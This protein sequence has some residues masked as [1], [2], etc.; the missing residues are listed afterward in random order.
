MSQVDWS[1]APE[2]AQ[3]YVEGWGFFRCDNGEW[4]TT[5]ESQSWRRTPYQSPE[6]FSWFGAA[7]WR[8]L[9]TPQWRGMQD[10]LPPVGTVCEYLDALNRWKEVRITGHAELGVCFRTKNGSGESYVENTV[11]FRPIETPERKAARERGAAV[12]AMKGVLETWARKAAQ[13]GHPVETNFDTICGVL[14]DH[15]IRF[16]EKP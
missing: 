6:N 4:W 14:Y 1:E 10:G 8:P 2:G 3:A 15:G 7:V 12:E 9:A 11:K 16:T 5:H 13:T